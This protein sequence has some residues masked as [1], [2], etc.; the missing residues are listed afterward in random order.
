MIFSS[1]IGTNLANKIPP[2]LGDIS[3]YFSGV[4]P[5][6]MLVSNTDPSEILNIV[7]ALKSSERKG[8]APS[9][10]EL[11]KMLLHSFGHALFYL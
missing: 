6:S 11:L 5:Y 9:H 8:V 7:H 4:Y 3:K 10:Q 2:V 1:N